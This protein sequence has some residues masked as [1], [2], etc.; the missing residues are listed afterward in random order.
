MT[1]EGS[2]IYT[3]DRSRCVLNI[4]WVPARVRL[5]L[6]PTPR[7]ATLQLNHSSLSIRSGGWGYCLSW[8]AVGVRWGRGGQVGGDGAGLAS[9][10]AIGGGVSGGTGTGGTHSR[11]GQQ[12][13]WSR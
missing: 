10:A 12:Y 11:P 5:S 7:P 1:D 3:S 2:L 9:E 4:I 13:G 6:P 8:R